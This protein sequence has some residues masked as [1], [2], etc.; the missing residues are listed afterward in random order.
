[1]GGE[2]CVDSSTFEKILSTNFEL[3]AE[4]VALK[5][6][7]N[8]IELT[9]NSLHTSVTSLKSNNK[10]RIITGADEKAAESK[11]RLRSAKSHNAMLK[12]LSDANEG[13]I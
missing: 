9:I 7:I 8:T 13:N 3:K 2:L 5:E 12:E 11:N 10:A 6:K 4:N 1:M